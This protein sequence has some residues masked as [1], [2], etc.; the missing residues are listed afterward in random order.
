MTK[1][2]PGDQHPEEYRKDL[3]PQPL[4][5]ENYG[6]TADERRASPV[7]LADIKEAHKRLPDLS[8]DELRRIPVVREDSRLEQGATYVDL[9][10]GR[11]E[12][13]ATAEMKAEPG[14]WIVP[15]QAVEYPLWNRLIG[16][17]EP[18]RT[19]ADPARGPIQ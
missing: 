8:T 9:A 17:R 5:G 16:V 11:R 7:L 4:A 13:T 1:Y 14:A 15:K 10:G 2:R 19:A 6:T 12:F 3:N 18:E